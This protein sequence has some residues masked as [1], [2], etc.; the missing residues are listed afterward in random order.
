MSKAY[1]SPA[2]REKVAH[3][4]RYRCG[5][6]Q[7]PAA[8]IGMPLEIEHIIPEALGGPSQEENLWL[9]CPTC[10]QK[11]G[12]RTTAIDEQAGAEVALFNPRQQRWHDHFAWDAGGLFLVGVTAVGR[13]TIAALD[14]NN[15]HIVHT[16]QT[17]IR[18]G[19][20][21]PADG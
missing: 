11:K 1:I 16:R 20:H 19:V 21:P 3:T 7:T 10:N 6:C 12:K 15:A 8:L 5:Y 17:W 13:A 9:A 4:A 2:L 14:M 18:W